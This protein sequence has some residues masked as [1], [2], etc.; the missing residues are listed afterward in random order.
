MF[1][2]LTKKL[3]LLR[4]Q[5][6]MGVDC[7]IAETPTSYFVTSSDL[8]APLTNNLSAGGANTQS[9]LA[10]VVSDDAH[11]S[12]VAIEQARER[13]ACAGTLVELREAITNF[14]YCPLKQ[15]A[16]NLVFADGNPLA[17]LM[18]VGEAPGQEEDR[19]GRPFVGVSGRLL[20][21]MLQSVGYKRDANDLDQSVYIS[22]VV[23]WRPP[24]NRDPTT[25]EIEMMTPFIMRHIAIV[26]PAVVIL[27]GNSACRALLGKAGITMLRGKPELVDGRVLMPMFH[28]AYLLRNPVAKGDSWEDLLLVRRIIR[29]GMH[30][31]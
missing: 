10:K 27:M 16:Q 13:S 28:P 23:P 18:V 2:E 9:K 6:D 22:N 15:G 24:G 25:A 29:D 17:K 26:A 21:V 12:C 8:N 14:N 3:A 7:A 5:A 19:Q 1:D 11:D 30:A 4:W 31:S 20:D